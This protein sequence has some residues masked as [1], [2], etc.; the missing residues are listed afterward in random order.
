MFTFYSK[1]PLNSLYFHSTPVEVVGK[2]KRVCLYFSEIEHSSD[3]SF[4][5]IEELIFGHIIKMINIIND[6]LNSPLYSKQTN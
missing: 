1:Y 4:C 6:V 3:G 2:E 5:V